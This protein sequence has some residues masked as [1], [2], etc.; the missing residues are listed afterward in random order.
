M[1]SGC[2]SVGRAV[3]SDTKDPRFKP[4]HRQSFIYQIFYQ[5]YHS[6]IV[7]TKSR[8]KKPGMAHLKKVS[9]LM[10]WFFKPFISVASREFTKLKKD[11]NDYTGAM[12]RIATFC[13]Q[14]E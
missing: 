6:I 8:K 12:N 2:G 14:M 4:P 13:F 9:V 1:G 11:Y 10:W 3:G 7:K 5:L